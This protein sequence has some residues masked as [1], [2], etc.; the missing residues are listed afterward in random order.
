MSDEIIDVPEFLDRVME[1]KDL[2]KELLDIFS[3]DYVQ[4]RQDLGKAV[5]TKDFE[6][7]RSVAHSLKGASGNI[8]AKPLRE[9]CV[10]LE[11]KG[12]ESDGEGLE[13]LLIDLDKQYAALEERMKTLKE[14]L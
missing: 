1:D 3:A 14:E 5:E 9:V 11:K 10:I 7:I 13:A 2:L 4:K 8:S 6:T 12:K